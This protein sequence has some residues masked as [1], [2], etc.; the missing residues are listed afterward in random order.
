MQTKAIIIGA[1][2]RIGQALTYE[3]CALYQTVIVVARTPPEYM[4]ENMHVYLLSDFANLSHQLS[5]IRLG[6]KTDAF[7]CLWTQET[8]KHSVQNVH[9]EYPFVFAQACYQQ[10]VRRLFI[11]TYTDVGR[12]VGHVRELL[13]WQLTQTM[14]WQAIV[15]FGVDKLVAPKHRLTL[16]SLITKGQ[17]LVKDLLSSSVALTPTQVAIAMAWVAYQSLYDASYL[18]KWNEKIPSYGTALAIHTI[19]HKQLELLSGQT[20]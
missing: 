11:S 5:A 14:A 15:V 1:T 19:T 13:Y 3:L 6:D 8:D 18:P 12:F 16:K 10:G 4:S 9:F 2:G 20:R 17:Y 7:C